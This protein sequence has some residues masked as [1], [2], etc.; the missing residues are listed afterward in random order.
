MR[1]FSIPPFEVTEI[2][3][4]VKRLC[5]ATN[6]SCRLHEDPNL[7]KQGWISQ[8]ALSE[9]IVRIGIKYG[10]PS[11]YSTTLHEIGPQLQSMIDA[12]ISRGIVKCE[13]F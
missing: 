3:P 8:T 2:W 4:V 5:E 1:N 10:I 13:D 6:V 11:R 7:E 12:L 9:D